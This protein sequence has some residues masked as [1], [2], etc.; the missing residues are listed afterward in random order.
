MPIDSFINVNIGS[1]L[2]SYLNRQ[3]THIHSHL[4]SEPTINLPDHFDH[5]VACPILCSILVN[6]I[7]DVCSFHFHFDYVKSNISILSVANWCYLGQLTIPPIPPC[8]TSNPKCDNITFITLTFWINHENS[9]EQ[10]LIVQV[11][12]CS[13][14]SFLSIFPCSTL[15]PLSLVRPSKLFRV[16]RTNI[17]K[18]RN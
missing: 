11:T 1:T 10:H 2:I 4:W 17:S 3:S 6:N 15:R 16:A 9:F 12:I 14:C 5:P 13:T 8:R 7:H 18:W